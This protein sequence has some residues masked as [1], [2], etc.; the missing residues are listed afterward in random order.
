MCKYAYSQF[1]ERTK[2]DMIFCMCENNHRSK[3]HLCL[4]QR[5]CPDKSRYIPHNQDK[6][7]CKFYED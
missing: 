2:K 6:M 5:Y 3:Q 1:N 4:C 7:H